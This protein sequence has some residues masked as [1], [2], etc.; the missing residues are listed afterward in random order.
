METDGF[1]DDLPGS[2]LFGGTTSY[3]KKEKRGLRYWLRYER[4]LK[5]NRS[6]ELSFGNVNNSRVFGNNSRT[7]TSPNYQNILYAFKANYLFYTAKRDAAVGGGPAIVY[8]KLQP[9]EYNPYIPSGNIESKSYILPG[10]SVTALWKFV[11]TKK[12]FM[13]IRTDESF[14]TSATINKFTATGRGTTEFKGTKAGS[15][16]GS[17]TV[18]VG[19]NF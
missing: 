12:G 15:F 18:G 14:T 6:I 8:Y 19:I 7:R 13:S 11:N 9:A 17:V 16:V 10:L 2:F 3:P 1:G 5:N 4:E